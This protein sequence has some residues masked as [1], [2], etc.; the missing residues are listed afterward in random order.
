MSSVVIDCF[1]SRASRY[2]ETHLIVAVDVIR[3]TTTAV[4]AAALGRP[5]HPMP[6]LEA[7]WAASRQLDRPLMVG[8][9]GGVMP[10][11]FCLNNS[12]TAIFN[13]TDIERPMILLST[14]GTPLLC[15][16]RGAPAVHLACLRNFR[17]QAAQLADGADRV[18]LIG[19][20]SRGT[21]RLEDQL[22][23]AWIAEILLDAGFQPEND[24]TLDLVRRWSGESVDRILESESAEYLIRTGQQEDL[25]FVLTRVDDTASVCTL[26]PATGKIVLAGSEVV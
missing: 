3:A 18:A 21:F 4:T 13:R 14:S 23:C 2:C 17:A 9:V 25:E 20:G 5:V 7:A 24:S 15:A 16:A 12:P 26:D 11:G 19:A 10:D 6:T 8:E 22:C 1:A